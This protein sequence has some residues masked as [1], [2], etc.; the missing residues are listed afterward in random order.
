LR[1]DA[2]EIVRIED[3]AVLEPL[4]QRGLA[5]HGRLRAARAALVEA[6]RAEIAAEQA[7][8]QAERGFAA[9]NREIVGAGYHD[10]G[11]VVGYLEKSSVPR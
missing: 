10:T 4:A 1:Q 6:Q 7:V 3:R 2:P 9:A 5:A 11:H 8:A